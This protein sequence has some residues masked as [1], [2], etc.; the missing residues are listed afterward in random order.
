MKHF[1]DY[2]SAKFQMSIL[3]L[4]GMKSNLVDVSNQSKTEYCLQSCL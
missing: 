4:Q 1:Q 2:Y 3:L